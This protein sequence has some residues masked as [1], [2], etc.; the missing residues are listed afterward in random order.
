MN[1]SVFALATVEDA[2]NQGATV[3]V[4]GETQTARAIYEAR[5]QGGGVVIRTCHLVV[6][7]R[8]RDP[9]EITW[10][11]STR[12]TIRAIDAQTLTLDLGYRVVTIPLHDGRPA[13]ETGVPLTVGSLI[14][15]QAGA[16]ECLRHL[17]RR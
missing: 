15:G 1:T 10:R 2:H 5:L 6:V 16:S 17:H 12:G 13:S 11:F 4:I 7:D 3:R 14:A 8:S 9:W